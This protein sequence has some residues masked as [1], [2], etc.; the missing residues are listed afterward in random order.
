[1]PA[2]VDMA[3]YPWYKEFFP[4]LLKP[5][6]AA[7]LHS[8]VSSLAWS[9][10][11]FLIGDMHEDGCHGFIMGTVDVL[12]YTMQKLGVQEFIYVHPAYRAAVL[13]LLLMRAFEAE[14]RQR[15][16]TVLQAG[17]SSGEQVDAVV[18]MTARLGYST[19]GI[20]MR[21]HIK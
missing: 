1:M 18:S 3:N 21:K 11:T 15:G 13:P 10:N 14:C 20:V 5:E 4:D 19:S 8:H 17:V 2:V 12:W 7:I 9:P 6:A 16:A